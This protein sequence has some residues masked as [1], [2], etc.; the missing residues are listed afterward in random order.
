MNIK[1]LKSGAGFTLIEL[2]VVIAIVGILSSL[3]VISM[4]N[5]RSKARDSRRLSDITALQDAVELYIESHTTPPDPAQETWA[6]LESELGSF[7]QGGALPLD[8]QASDGFRYVY[9]H[10]GYNYLVATVMENNQ[11]IPNEIDGA[12]N[13]TVAS[14]CIFSGSYTNVLSCIDTAGGGNISG[15]SGS[16]FCVGYSKGI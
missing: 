6:G 12:H 7:V 15:K 2:M 10:F 13:Y 14:E 8:P 9:C 4:S 1:G 3:A 5:S 16:V 11:E